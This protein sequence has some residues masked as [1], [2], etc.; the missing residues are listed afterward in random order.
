KADAQ[1]T[2]DARG[3]LV[4]PGL[5]DIHCH[6]AQTKDGPS[7]VLSD[8]VTSY[9]DAGSYGADGIDRAAALVRGGPNLGRILCNISRIGV[10]T[11]RGELHDLRLADV[12]RA[13]DAIERNRDVVVGIKARLSANVTGPNDL[14]AL[15]LAQAVAV[16]LELPVMVHIGQSY[17]PLPAILALLKPG[18]VITHLYAPGPNGTLDENGRVRPEVFS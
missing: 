6:A 1:Q 7:L 13:R 8:G 9:I 17:S 16:P 15:R 2:I 5:I 12:V 4:V 18:D 14:E 3:K 10:D 11:D